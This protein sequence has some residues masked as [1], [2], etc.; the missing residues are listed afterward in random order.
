MPTAQTFPVFRP[1]HHPRSMMMQQ[2]PRPLSVDH[3][4]QMIGP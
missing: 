3:C 4:V 2:L 1:T